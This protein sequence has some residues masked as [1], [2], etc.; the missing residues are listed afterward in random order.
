MSNHTVRYLLPALLL[1]AIA[2]AKANLIDV[3]N[4]DQVTLGTN[5]SL[6]FYISQ[7]LSSFGHESIYP[8]E[9][10]MILGSMPLGGPVAAIPGTSGVY[11]PGILFSGTLESLNGAISIPLTD[12]NAAR[13]DLPTGDMLLTPGSRSGG[14]YSGPVDLISADVTISSPEAAAIFAS[15]EVAIDI[16]NTGAPIT[17]GYPGS[18]IASDFTASF[19]SPDG[20]QSAGGR[21]LQADC[22]RNNT[23]EPGTVGL[24]IIGLTV[25]WGRRLGSGAG[26]QPARASQARS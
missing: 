9:I 18:P 3:T 10:E 14:S 22:V 7:D 6:I 1:A 11:S 20:T 5:D 21:V 15:G 23:P 26:S 4:T 2:P 8:G 17:I 24:L 12:P 13:L 16:R 25:L 19:I